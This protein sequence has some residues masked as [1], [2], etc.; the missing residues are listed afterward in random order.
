MRSGC[1]PRAQQLKHDNIVNLIEVVRDNEHM[2]VVMEALGGGEL[3]EQ[4]LAK[5]PFKED[6]ALA[7]F[8]QVHACICAF[9]PSILPH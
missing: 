3:F 9:P 2:Y 6:Y 4:L 8:A 1:S 5:G 7:V